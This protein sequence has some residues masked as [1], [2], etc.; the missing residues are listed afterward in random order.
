MTAPK[1]AILVGLLL[2]AD[3]ARRLQAQTPEGRKT[4]ESR[5]SVCHGADGNGGEM[6]PAIA[7]RV[8]NLSDARIRTTVLEGLP[9]RG[10]PASVNLKDSELTP[11]IS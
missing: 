2:T 1:A 3:S 5:C 8:P 10:M 6:G 11:L 4:F 7:D 9:Q